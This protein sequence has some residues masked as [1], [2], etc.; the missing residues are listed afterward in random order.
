MG[1]IKKTHTTQAMSNRRK[2]IKQAGI[3][4]AGL[5]IVP[6]YVLGGAGYIPPSDKLNVAFVGAWGK[7]ENHLEALGPTENVV[8]LCDVDDRMAANAWEMFP[9]ASR[10][11]DFRKMLDSVGK[12]IDGVV[13]T[14][15]DHTHAV[16]AMAAMQMGK[17][18]Y[19]EKP[20][21]HN[22][23]EARQLLE[24]SRKYKV[25]TQMGNQ[26]ASMDS[27][28]QVAEWIQAGVIG[29]VQKVHVWTNRPVWPQ[30]IP[31]PKMA[32]AIPSE[33][34]WDLWLG[35][36]KDRSYS[37][38]YL[39]FNWRGW[40]DFGTGSFGDMGC[41]FIDV[42]FRALKLTAPT[43]AEAVAT[44]GWPTSAEDAFRPDSPPSSAMVKI[45]FPARPGFPACELWWYDGGLKPMRPA[46]LGSNEEMSTADGGI[47]FEGSK[48]KLLAGIFGGEATLLP[49]SRM[50]DFKA[51]PAKYPRYKD[52]HQMIWAKACKGEGKTTSSF[53]TA[54]PLT[55][56]ILM[57]C[58]A[59]RC[60][61]YKRLK[62]GKNFDDW[63]PWDYPGRVRLDWDPVNLKV[64]NF[65]EANAWVKREYRNGWMW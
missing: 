3:A 7:A 10:H 58:L 9:K 56:A 2:F 54:G 14:T 8:A 49:K 46:E 21:T 51:P 44:V 43:S 27:H 65:D 57:G 13:V 39:P 47:L 6:R 18:V 41:H 31:T 23:W 48:G 36:A 30:G 63:D 33:L 40:W 19:V 25:V 4:T 24:A 52:S 32:D 22:I 60:A 37:D 1:K 45:D 11:K 17:H 15:P 34:D 5:T 16:A 62:P 64:K 55:E 29:T 53:E 26:G 61:D 59:V 38:K 20:L 12:D 28:A 35:P 42:V 50:K